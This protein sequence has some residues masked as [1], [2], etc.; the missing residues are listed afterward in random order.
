MRQ[1]KR[2]GRPTKAPKAGDRVSLGLRVT[3]EIKSRL[4]AAAMI[5]GRS[6]SQEAELR[7]EQSFRDDGIE[8]LLQEV[9]KRLPA[10]E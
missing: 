8:A 5:S 1:P 2:I 3:A 7:L 4:D 9:L 6:Q 10:Q